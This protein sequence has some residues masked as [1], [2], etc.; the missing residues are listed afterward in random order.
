MPMTKAATRARFVKPPELGT[1]LTST[2]ELAKQMTTSTTRIARGSVPA[3]G[4]QLMGS[5]LPLLDQ[6]DSISSRQQAGE[7]VALAYQVQVD[8]GAQIEAQVRLRSAET[9]GVNVERQQ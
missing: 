5:D 8:V 3:G 6:A 4:R 1:Q 2:D 7:V 9:G